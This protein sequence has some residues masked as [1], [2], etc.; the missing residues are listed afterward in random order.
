M[1]RAFDIRDKETDVV[2]RRRK[3]NHTFARDP[4]KSRFHTHNAAKRCGTND[5]A[6]GLSPQGD[7]TISGGDSGC[8]PTAGTAGCMFKVMRITRGA[9]REICKFGGHS[10]AKDQRASFPEAC[11]AFSFLPLE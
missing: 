3:G 9:R 1:S 11:N 6:D 4:I 8:R 2:K 10:F 7:M 5:R